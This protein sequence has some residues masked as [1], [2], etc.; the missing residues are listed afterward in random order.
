MI[1]D[2]FKKNP[3]LQEFH[4]SDPISFVYFVILSS[5]MIA[6]FFNITSYYGCEYGH[7]YKSKAMLCLCS[8]RNVDVASPFHF[9]VHV[10]ILPY[11]VNK[12]NCT[13]LLSLY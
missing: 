1:G 2:S 8:F 12:I 13:E 5:F 4:D 7:L 9:R 3:M 6:L 11:Q 10:Q